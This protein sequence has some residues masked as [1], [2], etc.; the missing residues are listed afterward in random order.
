MPPPPVTCVALVS[1][2][3]YLLGSWCS[4]FVGSVNKYQHKEM[5]IMLLLSIKTYL[6][7]CTWC[8]QFNKGRVQG[9]DALPHHAEEGGVRQLRLPAWGAG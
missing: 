8:D 3:Y 6:Y 7:L 4:T 1:P 5:Q 2:I 9:G